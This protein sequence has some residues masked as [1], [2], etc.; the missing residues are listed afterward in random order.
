MAA[1]E[2]AL[3][4]TPEAAVTDCEIMQS[5]TVGVGVQVLVP[6]W[7]AVGVEVKVKVGVQVR[8]QEGATAPEAVTGLFR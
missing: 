3:M 8:R 1:W 4:G 7:V 5:Q 2:G 6:V